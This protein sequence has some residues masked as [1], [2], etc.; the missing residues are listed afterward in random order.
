M[1]GQ[2]STP[3]FVAGESEPNRAFKL[4]QFISSIFPTLQRVVALLTGYREIETWDDQD[5][6][7]S[8]VNGNGIFKTANTAPTTITMFD[9]GVEGQSILVYFGDSDTT[10]DLTGG[11]LLGNAGIDWAPDVGD[12]LRATFI[13]PNWVVEIFD[14]TP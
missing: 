12:H 4:N 9:D 11:S 5:A 3:Q 10:I 1:S 2:V 6:T 14:N 8:V 7:P 13:P